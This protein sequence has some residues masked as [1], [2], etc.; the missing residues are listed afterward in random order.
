[1]RKK[2]KDLLVRFRDLIVEY[3]VIA[4]IVNYAIL[5]VV[6]V[7]FWS[8]IRLGWQPTS[9]TG[10]FGSW[11]AA[12]F[13]AKLVQPLRIAAT[14]AVTPFIAKWYES[15]VAPVAAKLHKRGPSRDA[16]L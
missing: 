13:L 3:G 10:R 6:I 7:G 4:V 9:T 11:G 15:R 2:L 12:Y 14:I 5:A 8:A 1:V 16:E